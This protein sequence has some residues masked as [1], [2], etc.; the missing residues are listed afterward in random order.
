MDSPTAVKIQNLE[1][2]Y[3]SVQAL[4]GVDLEIPAGE[5][6]G[7]LGPNGAGKSTLINCIVGLAK[8]THGSVEVFNHNVRKDPVA[9]K[10]LIGFSPQ[11]V[12]VERFFNL[13]RTLEFQGGFHGLPAPQAKARADQMLE[14]FGLLEKSNQQFFRLSGGMQKRLLVARALMSQPQLLIL[15][16]PTAGVDV[17]QRHELWDYLRD[18]NRDGTT[19]ILTTH[20]IDEA[21]ALCERVGIINHGR[22]LEL[23]APKDLIE[24][25]CDS[26]VT[27]TVE[28]KVQAQDF[29]D[30]PAVEVNGQFV[31][32]RTQR[33]GP[34]T[35]QL[36]ERVR[37]ISE[38]RVLDIQVVRG[39]LEEVFIKV[40]GR[41]MEEEAAR[42]EEKHPVEVVPS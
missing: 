5:F 2:K 11:E 7:L 17:A 28:G 20:Y 38:L 39:D 24:K 33:L 35:V 3:G 18:L 15:D 4:R 34:T 26:Q 23:G 12:N 13:R 10:S 22:V 16:E 6:F 27:L 30:I 29:A 1:K 42:Q 41:T 40:T 8:P 21:E 31:T 25:Y 36:L 37:Q 9:A 14:K 19:I 32:A